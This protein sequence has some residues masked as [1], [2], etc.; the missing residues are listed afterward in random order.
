MKRKKSAYVYQM[1]IYEQIFCRFYRKIGTI[2]LFFHQR[3][4]ILI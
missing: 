2:E 4:K 3:R 1:N